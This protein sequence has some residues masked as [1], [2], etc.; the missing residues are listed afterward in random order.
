MIFSY[1]WLQTYFKKPLPM[2]EKLAELL[3]MHIFEVE[4]LEEIPVTAW[5]APAAFTP[6]DKADAKKDYAIDVKIL[7]DRASYAYA[8]LSLARE[9]NAI[10]ESGFKSFHCQNVTGENVESVIEDAT[11]AEITV[12]SITIV[13]PEKVPIFTSRM[14]SGIANGA[15][16]EWLKSAL[17]AAGQRSI[18]LIVDLTNY[19]M[20]DVG[21]PMHAFD[22]DKVKGDITIRF[23]K[24]G[25]KLILL[26]GREVTLDPETLVIADEEGAL[27]IAG[28]KGG[29]KAEVDAN[30]KRIIITA[31]NFDSTYI[32]KAS[33]KVGIKNDS[34]KRYENAV[35]LERTFIAQSEFINLLKDEQS[36][37]AF[38]RLDVRGASAKGVFA[39]RK[40]IAVNALFISEKIGMQVTVDEIKSIMKNLGIEI[41]DNGSALEILPPLYR[42][43]LVIAEDIVEEIARLKGTNS[44]PE[45]VPQPN[46]AVPALPSFFYSNVARNALLGLGFSETYTHTLIEEGDYALANPLTVERS[47]LRNNLASNMKKALCLNAQHIDLLGTDSADG[48]SV[49]QDIRIFD[50][51]HV[52][53]DKKESW[54]LAIGVACKAGKGAKEKNKTALEHAMR[55]LAGSFGLDASHQE[56]VE[57]NENQTIVE[58]ETEPIGGSVPVA[59]RIAEINFENV[60]KALPTPEEF[61]ASEAG[62]AATE[63]ANMPAFVDMKTAHRFAAFSPYPYMTR[64]IAVFIPGPSGNAGRL[65]DCI[66]EAAAS[67]GEEGDGSK[68]N[69]ILKLVRKF[70]EF[71]K[72]NK[73]TGEVEKTSYGF[74]MVFQSDARTLTE[75]EVQTVMDAILAKIGEKEGWEVR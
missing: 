25:E 48:G 64:D 36:G 31:G 5:P 49:A 9:I 38:G 72:K 27:D 45:V 19:V 15:S 1:N 69:G 39:P 71:E 22:A 70:D 63:W 13:D 24:Q 40:T 30:T 37:I 53:K 58:G 11:D 42:S 2:P 35:T 32:R 68:D 4:G 62:K 47:H 61:S 65:R 23:A 55:T 26:D 41:A 28:V 66:I 3:T 50:I 7:P 46:I 75:G 34:T 21:Q 57:P 74:R 67:G 6:A 8:H 73:E 54:S 18:S 10:T 20:L 16:P 59:Y 12:P 43:D 44:I 51:G 17:L 60:L 52:F 29:K 33:Q 14:V 56:C